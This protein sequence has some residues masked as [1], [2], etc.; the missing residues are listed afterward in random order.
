MGLGAAM[1]NAI[2][3]ATGVRFRDLPITTEKV[4]RALKRREANSR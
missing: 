3:D 2:G 1:A 4:L